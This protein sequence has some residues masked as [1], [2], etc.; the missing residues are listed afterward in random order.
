MESN[1]LVLEHERYLVFLLGSINAVLQGARKMMENSS[2][3]QADVVMF[4]NSL[5]TAALDLK[6]FYRED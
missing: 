3:R 6:P 4:F 5:A 2:Y 1:L